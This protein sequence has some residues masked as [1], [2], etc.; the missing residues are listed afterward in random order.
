M[1]IRKNKL[2]MRIL[3]YVIDVYGIR[4]LFQNALYYLFIL[5]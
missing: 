2:P 5:K 3:T 4:L 1:K